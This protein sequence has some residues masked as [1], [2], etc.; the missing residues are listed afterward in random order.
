MR[1]TEGGGA[2]SGARV[3]DGF[4]GAAAAAT[5]SAK[6]ISSATSD[7]V[8]TVMAAF[9]GTLVAGSSAGAET[10]SKVPKSND[11]N[12]SRAIFDDLHR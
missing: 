4:S 5:A 7:A 3:R 6:S 12:E 11:A 8:S 1:D 2:F 9:A 10:A